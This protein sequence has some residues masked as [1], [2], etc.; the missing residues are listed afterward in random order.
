MKLYS[1]HLLMGAEHIVKRSMLE[2]SHA[3]NE[4]VEQ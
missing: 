4:R 2:C 3:H 1:D